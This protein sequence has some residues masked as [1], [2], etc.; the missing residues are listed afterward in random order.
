MK[1]KKISLSPSSSPHSAGL[2][3]IAATKAG[4]EET[5]DLR[6]SDGL[7]LPSLHLACVPGDPVPLPTIKPGRQGLCSNP[8]LSLT[9]SSGDDG[10]SPQEVL[11]SG[12]VENAPCRATGRR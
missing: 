5:N 11:H 2:R 1:K 6:S 7:G 12:S 3:T 9:H 4:A 8:V 10:L